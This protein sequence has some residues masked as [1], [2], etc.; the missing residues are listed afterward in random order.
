MPLVYLLQGNS[1]KISMRLALG[2]AMLV[3]LVGLVLG[4]A[5]GR[6]LDPFAV[7]NSPQQQVAPTRVPLGNR[8]SIQHGS[9]IV[10]Y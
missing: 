9:A 7:P 2:I 3:L 8:N 10:V 4:V 1:V 5:I 6:S